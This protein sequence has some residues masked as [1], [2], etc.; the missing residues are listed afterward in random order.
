MKLWIDALPN[1]AGLCNNP[2][3]H[4]CLIGYSMLPPRTK[5]KSKQEEK[6]DNIVSEMLN[7]F[8]SMQEN[9]ENNKKLYKAYKQVLILG[10]KIIV[11]CRYGRLR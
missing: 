1:L 4:C 5:Q 11:H 7:S 8:E 6:A 9:T 10:Q 3:L 2:F